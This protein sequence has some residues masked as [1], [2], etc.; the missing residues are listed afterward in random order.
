MK[1]Q[2][3]KQMNKK[4]F[5]FL[6]KKYIND[7]LRK[8]EIDCRELTFNQK[9]NLIYSCSVLGPHYS[10]YLLARTYELTFGKDESEATKKEFSKKNK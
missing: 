5:N 2:M 1:K 7:F 8:K 9:I 4:K 3:K 10:N 6:L